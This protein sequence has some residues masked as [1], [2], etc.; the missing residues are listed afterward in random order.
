MVG[1]ILSWLLLVAV[2]V[3]FIWL[4]TRAW[5]SRRWYVKWPGVLLSGLLALLLTVFSVVALIGLV[6]IYT[7]AGTAV[8][9]VKVAGTPEQIQ[10]GQHLADAFCVECHSTT[11]QLPMIGGRD[12]SGDLGIPIGKFVSVNL[13]PGG[14][15]KDWSDGE[16]LRVLREGVDRDGRKLLVMGAANVRYM[17]D[18][19]IQSVIA[20]LRSQPAVDNPTLNPPDQPT[21]LGLVV[22][23]AGLI[24][25]L[26]PVTGSVSAPPRGE[27][28][29]YGKYVLSFQ[30]C[31]GCHG[32]DLKGGTSALLPKGPNLRVVKGWSRD[33][34]IATLRTGVD[35][36]GHALQPP[37]PWKSIGRLDDT[38]LG[39]A[40][41]FIASLP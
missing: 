30:D 35:P 3:F 11:G 27:T 1:N 17:S 2:T 41:Q 38:E 19:D 24:P 14:P 26:P 40:Y 18:E 12:L 32:A 4:V 37:M 29:N 8:Q 28:V 7:P 10:R 15:L 6:K 25:A 20:Y 36:G 9:E 23:G 31:Y 39:A 33:Q 13:T 22:A 21:L 16:I 34:F 5:K